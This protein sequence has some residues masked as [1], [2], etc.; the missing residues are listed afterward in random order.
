MRTGVYQHYK[1]GRYLVLGAAR[2]TETDEIMVVY[3]PLYEHPSGGMPMQVRPME[4]FLGLAPDAM[5]AAG[6]D[7]LRQHPRRKMRATHLSPPVRVGPQGRADGSQATTCRRKRVLMK[8]TL[9]E[10]QSLPE[11][12]RY[13]IEKNALGRL[14]R[15]FN[16]DAPCYAFSEDDQLWTD[17]DGAH[18]MTCK[19]ADGRTMKI[20]TP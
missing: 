20:R 10:C 18:W 13:I 5:L 17:D 4:M 8:R 7:A 6:D 16:R 14:T 11:L 12:E 2:H 3:T 1:G 15:R 9:V 19:T